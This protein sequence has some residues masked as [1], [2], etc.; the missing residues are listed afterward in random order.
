MQLAQKLLR[1]K[2]FSGI[3]PAKF[4]FIAAKFQEKEYRQGEVMIREGKTVEAF[5]IIFSGRA[6]AFLKDHHGTPQWY[7][8]LY[9]ADYFGEIELFNGHL[10]ILSI[11][12][13][14]PVV[15][16][17]L[18]AEEFWHV[19]DLFSDIKDYLYRRALKKMY[20]MLA[21]HMAMSNLSVKFNATAIDPN[22]PAY[23]QKALDYIKINFHMPISL[24]TV[25]RESGVSRYHLSR[26]FR[27]STGMTFKQY[28]NQ[29]R[30]SE[31]KLLMQ[32]QNMNVSD[33]CFSSGFNDLSHFSRI[34]KRIEKISPSKFRQLFCC[35]HGISTPDLS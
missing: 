22:Y 25:S 31:A 32:S 7:C 26:M 14:Q 5:D 28:L 30:V 20:L 19:L 6:T 12:C 24:D 17:S 8:D 2:P 29:K 18:T 33:A 15:C 9:E 13:S 10:S 35:R 23:V 11:I 21:K 1:H 16:Y 4:Q 34:F 27:E 3:N